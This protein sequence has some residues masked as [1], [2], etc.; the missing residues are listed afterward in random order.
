MTEFQ[1]GPGNGGSGLDGSSTDRIIEG[2]ARINEKVDAM[3]NQRLNDPDSLGDKAVK[4]ALPSIAGF[5]AGKL[6]TLVWNK[7]VARKRPSDGTGRA[8]GRSRGPA[9][10]PVHEHP[11]RRIVRRRGSRGLATL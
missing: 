11:V 1:D 10:E 5:V 3:R 9:G 8:G 4:F 2:F 6:F 7:F